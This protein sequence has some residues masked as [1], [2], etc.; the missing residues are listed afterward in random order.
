MRRR[1]SVKDRMTDRQHDYSMP[2]SSAL[3][4][5]TDRQHDYRMPRGS[6]HRGIMTDS[7]ITVY[8]VSS[9]LG[10]MTHTQTNELLYASWLRPPRHNYM[11][12]K[13]VQKEFKRY[14]YTISDRASNLTLIHYKGDDS[15]VNENLHV[16]T[17]SS[18]LRELEN[19]TQSPSVVYNHKIADC[20]SA[21]LIVQY[22]YLETES[23]C[24]IVNISGD[25]HFVCLM[26]PLKPLISTYLISADFSVGTMQLMPLNSGCVSMVLQSVKFQCTL[27]IFGI[28]F[29]RKTIM[30]GELKP[31]S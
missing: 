29:T 27:V 2:R 15:I 17:C 4:I 3:G 11:T 31:K 19:T 25:K 28:C 1:N 6:A 9:A 16:R 7:T 12:G 14:A 8:L 23:K 21:M 22:C 26:M 20:S 18:V 13:G 30:F 24:Q 10:I 5:M